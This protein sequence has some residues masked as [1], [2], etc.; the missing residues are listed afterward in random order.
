MKRL[1]P[2]LMSDA[3]DRIK[4]INHIIMFTTYLHNKDRFIFCAQL[5]S[6]FMHDHIF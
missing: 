2:H 6:Y 3:S 1:H 5:D 4:F